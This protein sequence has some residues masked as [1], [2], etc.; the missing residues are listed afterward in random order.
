MMRS[1]IDLAYSPTMPSTSVPIENVQQTDGGSHI[2]S[3]GNDR[4]QRQ[5]QGSSRLRDYEVFADTEITAEGDF[6]HMALLADMEP[7]CFDQAIKEECWINAMKEEIHSIEKNGTWEL[8]TLPKGKKAIAVKWVYKL[9]LQPDGTIA[10]HKAR[11]VAKGFLQK[12][13][14]D[15]DEVFAPVARMETVRLV[16]AMASSKDWCIWQMDVKS[17][18]LNGPLDKE[19]YVTQPL[20]FEVA[21]QEQ[22]VYKLHK[23]LYGLKQAPRAWNKRIDGFLVKQGMTRCKT[24]HGIY[25]KST[26]EAAS[27]VIC[28]Y[29]D[30]LLIT[31]CKSEEVESIR[32]GLKFEFEM[33][34]LGS[35]SY[36][37]GIEF[38]K[39]SKGILMHQKKYT[40]DVLERFN[41]Q[42]CNPATTPV[43]PGNG[44]CKGKPNEDS[45]DSTLYR[46]VIGSLRYIC[47]TRPDISYGVGL[48]SRYM[49]EPK[50]SHMIA[51]K[52]VLRYLKG[53][54]DMG[55]LFPTQNR[56]E[57]MS[58]IGF[59]DA[60]WSGDKDDRKSTTGY[61]FQLNQAP[62]SWSSKK[63]KSVALSSCE[64]EYVAACLGGCQAMWLQSLL[65]EIGLYYE[66]S[67]LLMVDNKSAINLAKNP[68]AHGRSKHIETKYHYL[69]DLVEKGRLKLEFCK[70]ENQLAD[71]LT[72][73]L[74]RNSFEVQRSKLGMVNQ[75]SMN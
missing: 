56:A 53:T 14:V 15:Y 57:T 25:I 51:A 49:E 40:L 17:A 20:G 5:R 7:V 21:G 59:T 37:L 71:I 36:F 22:K 6:V 39:T 70:S 27:V 28:L 38:L 62:I 46:Q 50:Q 34:D 18:F 44:L 10:K 11:L 66:N 68:I 32:N 42:H 72:K 23:A 3:E 67:M 55:I 43:E 13:E 64:A 16:I 12:P 52:R 31:G 4:P 24:E 9:K 30:D 48:I 65:E 63:Q 60:D 69:R 33:S 19:V 35:L 73:P 41:M 58:M 1:Q 47:N 54:M 74:R 75:A 45:V 2:V 61:V 8:I 29:V 26:P